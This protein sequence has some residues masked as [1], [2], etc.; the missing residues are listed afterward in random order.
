MIAAAPGRAGPRRRVRSDLSRARAGAR[1]SVNTGPLSHW[2]RGAGPG[3]VAGP[4]GEPAGRWA[5]SGPGSTG[6]RYRVRGPRQRRESEPVTRPGSLPGVRDRRGRGSP[7]PGG[8][9]GRR[10]PARPTGPGQPGRWS[11]S[12]MI[13]PD[14][15]SAGLRPGAGRPPGRAA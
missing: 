10:N 8:S 13:G 12:G 15:E 2:P 4:G 14:S 6:V 1:L 7:G 5:L 9:A 11:E 3:T